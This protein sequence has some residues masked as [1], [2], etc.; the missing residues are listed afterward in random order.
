MKNK[1]VALLGNMNNNNFSI[2]RYLR[3]LGVDAHLLLF[4]NDGVDTNAHFIPESDTWEYEKWKPYIH[5]IDYGIYPI[6][7]QGEPILVRVIYFLSRLLQNLKGKKYSHVFKPVSRRKIEMSL[8]GFDAFIGSGLTAAMLMRIGLKQDIF[9]PYGTGIEYLGSMPARLDLVQGNPI[10]RYL[11]KTLAKTQEKAIKNTK[12]C[13]NGEMSLTKQTFHEIGVNFH[14]INIPMVYNKGLDF[15]I[16]FIEENVLKI[17]NEMESCDFVI[18]NHSRQLWVRKEGYSEQEWEVRS[19]HNE[20]LFK[21]ISQFIKKRP[22]S[23]C[24]LFVLEYGEDVEASKKLCADLNIENYV[25]WLPKMAR[26]ELMLLLKYCHIGVGEF[27]T[28]FGSIW[29]GTGWEVLA[30]GKPLLQGFNFEDGEFEHSFKQPKP[31]M[32]P[33]KKEE[34]ILKHLIEIADN[35]QKG[36]IIGD[37][38]LNWFNLYG[39]IGLAEQWL[40]LMKL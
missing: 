27:Y 11:T 13:I 28:E 17:K 22:L 26:K 8:K 15:G 40:K 12:V 31:P 32:L 2:M 19:K 5:R 9:Y 3:D 20:W 37:G 33:V 6:T 30:M 38:A 23:N 35:P 24:K 1:R 10:K 25:V 16:N 34:D 4:K 36:K 29:G 18:L 14:P 21:S 39:G 7:V